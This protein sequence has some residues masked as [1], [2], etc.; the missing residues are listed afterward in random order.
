MYKTTWSKQL[1]MNEWAKENPKHKVLTHP[2]HENFW[3]RMFIWCH[4]EQ[5]RTKE[6]TIDPKM[7]ILDV[8]QKAK[9]MA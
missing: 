9:L 5:K 1:R 4:A 8:K 3:A 7:N 2:L 6:R